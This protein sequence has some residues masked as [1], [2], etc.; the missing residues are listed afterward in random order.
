[1]YI[2]SISESHTHSK[3]DAVKVKLLLWLDPK[4]TLPFNYTFVRLLNNKITKN[5]INVTGYLL[6]LCT[7]SSISVQCSSTEFTCVNPRKCVPVSYICDG[8]NDCG[9]NS[10]ETN[11]AGKVCSSKFRSKHFL[12]LWPYYSFWGILNSYCKFV[13]PKAVPQFFINIVINKLKHICYCG[14]II[15]FLRNYFF[16]LQICHAKSFKMIYIRSLYLNSSLR[17]S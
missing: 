8:D 7:F 13:M 4:D 1:M 2:H 6:S 17:Y 5:N 15:D 9:D 14:C 16:I 10:D 12:L 3:V 11:C